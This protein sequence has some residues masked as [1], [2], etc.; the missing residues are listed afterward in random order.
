MKKINLSFINKFSD[1]FF[2]SDNIVC[3]K[4]D[5]IILL[6]LFLIM[7]FGVAIYDISLYHDIA[8]GDMYVNVTK[9]ELQL[10]NIDSNMLQKVVND[11][12]SIKAEIAGIKQQKLIDTS[13]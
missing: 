9:Q 5:W 7:V 13:L 12:E 1:N 6:V 8:N 2:K 3:P 10:Q 4:R 11:F